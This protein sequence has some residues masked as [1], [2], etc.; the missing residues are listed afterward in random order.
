[1]NN[2]IGD[3]GAGGI[4]AM[5]IMLGLKMIEKGTR[6]KILKLLSENPLTI[7]QLAKIIGGNYKTIW[8]HVKILEAQGWVT[9]SQDKNKPGK[10]INVS[11]TD[12]YKKMKSLSKVK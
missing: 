2:P 11:L 10:P 3:G 8:E 12:A 7:M 4:V 1:M 5:A 6:K 9:L